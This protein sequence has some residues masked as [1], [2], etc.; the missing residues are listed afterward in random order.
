M[1]AYTA[2]VKW[3]TIANEN[4]P[5]HK[6]DVYVTELG[7]RLPILK[8][9]NTRFDAITTFSEYLHYLSFYY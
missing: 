4:T 6:P 7:I 9:Q 1:S 2:A 5:I 8:T 3:T